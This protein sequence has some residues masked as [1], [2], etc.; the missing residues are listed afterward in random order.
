MGTKNLPMPLKKNMRRDELLNIGGD[1]SRKVDKNSING[2][3]KTV[4]KV[5]G[6]GFHGLDSAKCWPQ[7]TKVQ[8]SMGNPI[9]AEFRN[10]SPLIVW[11]KPP[12]FDEF[13]E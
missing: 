2:I 1:K 8:E 13:L 11:D 10:L 12:I 9:R 4:P 6:V 7:G 3:V 5:V